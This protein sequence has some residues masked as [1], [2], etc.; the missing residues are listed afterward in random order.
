MSGEICLAEMAVS[1]RHGWRQERDI[2]STS[3][4]LLAAD[5]E[6]PFDSS[7]NSLMREFLFWPHE[8]CGGI[9]FPKVPR[10]VKFRVLVAV[11]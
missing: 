7:G 6:N 2:V 3:A 5:G 8:T 1:R 11:M 4:T 10:K 9:V